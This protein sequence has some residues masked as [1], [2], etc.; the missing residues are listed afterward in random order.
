MVELSSL[1]DRLSNF[2]DILEIGDTPPSSDQKMLSETDV[3]PKV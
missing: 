2:A 3:A 1:T